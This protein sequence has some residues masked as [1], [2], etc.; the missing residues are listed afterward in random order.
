MF[1]N[2]DGFFPVVPFPQE[3]MSPMPKEPK[4]IHP[5]KDDKNKK[6]FDVLE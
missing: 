1:F 5:S 2:N 3:K 4:V 6:N